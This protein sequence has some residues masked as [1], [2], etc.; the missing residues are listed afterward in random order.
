VALVDVLPY[1]PFAE[2]GQ[3]VDGRFRWRLGVRPLDEADW[4]EFGPDAVGPDGWIAAKPALIARHRDVV[5]A[6]HD[7]IER[8][9]ADVA[10]SVSAYLRVHHP[11]RDATLDSSRHPLEAA[12]LLVPEDVVLLVERDGRLVVGGG[13]VCFP[14]RWD[15]ASK[16][17][18]E[19]A[20]VHA[21]VSDLNDEIGHQIDAF[22]HRLASDRSWWR[23]GWGV[24]DVPDGFAPPI[25]REAPTALPRDLYL[26]VE[27]ETLRR[28]PSTDAVVFTIRTYI[29]HLDSITDERERA[30]I[31]EAV[32]GMAT[33]VRDY[34]ELSSIAAALIERLHGPA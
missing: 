11:E 18:L 17:G 30:A 25:D 27:R 16:V 26:R 1:R 22:L 29:A 23:L 20:Q 6:M 12:A 13:V 10:Q 19:L 4:F 21:P 5:V 8:E 24:I 9:A 28:L 32:D 31:A 7:G 2:R 3:V 15:L 34:K 33:G 14:N